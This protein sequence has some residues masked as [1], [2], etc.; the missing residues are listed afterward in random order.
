MRSVYHL[1]TLGTTVH[2]A[3]FHFVPHCIDATRLVLP[4][5][6]WACSY[7]C[8]RR[9][10]DADPGIANAADEETD[11][12][13]VCRFCSRRRAD[14]TKHCHVCKTCVDGFDH[15]CDVLDKCIGSGN[16]ALFRRFLLFHSCFLLFAT[17][18]TSQLLFGCV[19]RDPVGLPLYLSLIVIEFSFGTAFFMF[20]MFHAC[21][22]LW[23]TRTYDLIKFF[24]RGQPTVRDDTKKKD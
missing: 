13:N 11:A 23:D 7:A 20:W 18:H 3:G 8:F 19:E 14:H 16:I 6:L 24:L 5:L 10:V 21:L 15:H 22:A 1:V 17:F 9:L 12:T 2:Y 4:L